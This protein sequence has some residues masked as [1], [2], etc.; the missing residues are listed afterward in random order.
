[1]KKPRYEITLKD[2]T[3]DDCIHLQRALGYLPNRIGR[4]INAHI[5]KLWPEYRAWRKANLKC[6]KDSWL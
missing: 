4:Q 2:L 5:L 1:M 3:I 6:A